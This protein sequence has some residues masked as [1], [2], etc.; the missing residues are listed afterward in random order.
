MSLPPCTHRPP[1]PGCPRY[2]EAGIDAGPHSSLRHVAAAH[3]VALDDV[4]EGAADAFR[5]RARLAVRGRAASPKLGIFQQGTHRIADIPSCAVHHPRINEAAAAIKR[6]IRA[7]DV[8]PYADAPRRGLLRYVQIVVERA[9][10]RVQI[11]LV[12]NCDSPRPVLAMAG[13]LADQ[14]GERLQGLWWNGNT[15]RTNVIFGPHWQHLAGEEAVREHIGGADVFFPPGA[16]GQS[17][18]DVADR[19]V[20]DVHALV[21]DGAAVAELYA[22]C[23]SFGLG[24]LRRAREVRFNEE[25]GH[26]LR[27][28]ELGLAALPREIGARAS[29]FGGDAAEQARMLDGADVVIVDPPRKGLAAPLAEALAS[30]APKMLA[31]V[32]C[33]PASLRRDV[34]VLSAGGRMRLAGLRP[35]ALFPYTEHVETL[36]V[37]RA[38]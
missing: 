2:G 18:L 32:S 22:G 25:S 14:L 17:N 37:L 29:I 5:V 27:G 21:P 10:G 33:D 3:S 19:I 4:V 31:Y 12:A 28:L 34:A 8:A 6:A 1:C 23:G 9:S 16:F 26:G 35:Y 30:T 7:C 36:A 38:V 20:A 15:E 11:T 24:L 13:A